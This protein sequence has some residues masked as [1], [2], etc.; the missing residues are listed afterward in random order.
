MD[1][2]TSWEQPAKSSV[3]N[4]RLLVSGLS[5]SLGPLPIYLTQIVPALGIIATLMPPSSS[6]Q[7]LDMAPSSQ[8]RC[9]GLTSY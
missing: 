3:N 5:I 1:F 9:L 8:L 4:I 2:T 7:L 6:R